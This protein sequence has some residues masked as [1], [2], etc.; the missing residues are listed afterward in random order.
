MLFSNVTGYDRSLDRRRRSKSKQNKREELLKRE[1]KIRNTMDALRD[2]II[3]LMNDLRH[4]GKV[5]FR[6]FFLSIDTTF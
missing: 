5:D 2:Q 1:Q 3:R 6:L 4:L